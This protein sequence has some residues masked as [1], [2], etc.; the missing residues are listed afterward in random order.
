MDISSF[1]E[2]I[3]ECCGGSIIHIKVKIGKRNMF[4]LAF[5]KWRRRIE[6]EVNEKPEGGKAN[7]KILE[8]I[9]KFFGL[10][11]NS[12]KIE[13]GS[14]SREKGIWVGMEKEKVIEKLKNGL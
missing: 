7:K 4:P 3:E 1:R 2:A 14:K 10:D 8:T 13:Y 11:N 5:D 12:V 9:A 6:I